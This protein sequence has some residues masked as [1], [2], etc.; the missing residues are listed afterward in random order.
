[1]TALNSRYTIC[2]V[3]FCPFVGQKISWDTRGTDFERNPENRINTGQIKAASMTRL[4]MAAA[5]RVCLRD[6]SVKKYIKE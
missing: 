6:T 1:M 5:S 3:L 2:F 4:G